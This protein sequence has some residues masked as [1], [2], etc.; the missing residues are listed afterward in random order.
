MRRREMF[1]RNCYYR[2]KHRFRKGFCHLPYFRYL[3]QQY[4]RQPVFGLSLEADGLSCTPEAS[5]YRLLRILL[6]DRGCQ[7]TKGR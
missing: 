4:C 1:R 6:E 7:N 5:F 2:K 3:R